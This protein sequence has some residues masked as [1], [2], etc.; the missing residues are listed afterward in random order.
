MCQVLLQEVFAFFPAQFP[1][2]GN[3]HNV[4]VEFLVVVEK[5][6]EV[7]LAETVRKS[8]HAK[9]HPVICAGYAPVARCGEA[10]RTQVNAGSC[11]GR[12]SDK[13]SA[14]WHDLRF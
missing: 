8:N 4:E 13:L 12:S 9:V 5:T 6:R 1:D 7:R 3:R 11:A 14:R 10:Q 2:I